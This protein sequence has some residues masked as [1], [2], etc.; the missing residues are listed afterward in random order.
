MRIKFSL[1]NYNTGGRGVA[2]VSPV[3][4]C[5][6]GRGRGRGRLRDQ[7]SPEGSL[8]RSS[9]GSC[10]SMSPDRDE[11]EEQPQSPDTGLDCGQAQ[12][13]SASLDQLHLGIEGAQEQQN[14]PRFSKEEQFPKCGSVDANL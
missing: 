14:P 2:G 7:I 11:C 4:P 3:S 1:H 10:L 9:S 8:S 5:V 6:R 12:N 13:V